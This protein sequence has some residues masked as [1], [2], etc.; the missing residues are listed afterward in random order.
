MTSYNYPIRFFLTLMPLFAILSA[1]F[2]GDLYALAKQTGN[3]V[4]AR[5]LSA[6]LMLVLMFSLARGVSTML[7][8]I[9]DSRLPASEFVKTL[10]A[11]TSLESTFYGPTLPEGHFKREHNYPLFFQKSPDQA[12]PTNKNYEYNAGEAGLEERK[13]DYLIVDSFTSDKFENP[14]VCADM[15]VECDFFKQLETGQSNHYRLLTEFKYS[16]PRWLPQIQI[17]FVNPT[18]RIY[19]RTE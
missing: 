11:G 19:E 16:L 1:L 5:L 17:D 18:L 14:Y 7:L 8:F 9:N 10:P 3:P 15:Q 2:I 12:I 6:G 13:T 4:Y